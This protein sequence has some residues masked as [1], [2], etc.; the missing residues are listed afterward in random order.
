M[1]QDAAR[2]RA[3][4]A[5]AWTSISSATTARPRPSSNSCSASP[6]SAARPHAVHALVFAGR[7]AGGRRVAASYDARAKT[8]RLDLAQTVPPTPGQP[9]KEPMV[10]PLALGLVGRDGARPA[11]QAR[12]RQA[13]RARRDRARPSRARAS[14]STGI[15]ERAGAVDS[16]AASRRRSSSSPICRPTICGSSR[17]ATAIRSIAG[18]RCRR[19]RRALLV[20]NVARLRAGSDAAARRG[21]ARRA[22]RD[23]RRHGARAGLRRAGADACRARPTSPA[24]SAATSIPTRSSAPARRCAR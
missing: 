13:A 11:A 8:Y 18:R 10:I 15:A 19:W 6:T 24:R 4:S 20:D 12:R 23:P 2:R 17:R 3:I 21:P 7:H 16:T 22:G 9:T 1:M 5:R 14:C